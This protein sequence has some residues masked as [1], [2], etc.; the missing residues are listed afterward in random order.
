ME[1]FNFLMIKTRISYTKCGIEENKVQTISCIMLAKELVFLI[2]FLITFNC[3]RKKANTKE[4]NMFKE[5]P[6]TT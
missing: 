5:M 3:I 6:Q 4:G 1:P 2:N